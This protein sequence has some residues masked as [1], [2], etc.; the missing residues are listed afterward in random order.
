[1]AGTWC[2]STRSSQG[3]PA[4]FDTIREAV[5]Q[6]WLEERY[7]EI[8]DTAYDEMLSRYTIVLPDPGAVDL[9]PERVSGANDAAASGL[10]Q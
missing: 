5:S 4:A 7:R 3:Q 8:R 9:G 2:G 1:M 6:A 10:G